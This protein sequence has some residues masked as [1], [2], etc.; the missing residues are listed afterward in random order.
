MG[1]Q[2]GGDACASGPG[3]GYGD[4][5]HR[6]GVG[7]AMLFAD[8]VSGSLAGPR[9]QCAIGVVY[10]PDHEMGNYVPTELGKRYEAYV[11]VDETSPLNP[12]DTGEGGLQPTE[13]YLWGL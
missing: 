3:G 13:G 10:D 11:H 8:D 9:G 4:A 2:A 6:A 7:D 12:I 5:F 1:R